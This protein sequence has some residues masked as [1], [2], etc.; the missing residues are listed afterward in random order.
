MADERIPMR[1]NLPPLLKELKFLS[2][3]L[4]AKNIASYA[5]STAFF[6]FVSLIPLLML[7]SALLPLTGVSADTLSGLVTTFTP[8]MADTLVT[9]IIREAYQ[10]SSGL[11]S[12]S[13]IVI[14]YTSCMGMLALIRGMNRIFDIDE[15]RN[16]FLLVAVAFFYT[17]LLIAV[18]LLSLVLNVFGETIMKFVSSH[19]PDFIVISPLFYN[20]RYLVV[21]AVAVLLFMLIY[22]FVPGKRQKFRNQWPG[23][24]FSALGWSIF[25]FVYSQFM[26]SDNIYNTYYGSLATIVILL[27]WLYGCFYI[28]LMGAYIN[29][30]LWSLRKIGRKTRMM[31]RR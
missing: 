19:L 14:V 16:Y 12:F 6:F 31:L 30:R 22:T 28:L 20:V 15:K 24:L 1:E 21:M 13:L 25:S 2:N 4:T 10:G 8:D 17:F 7:L 27:L 5:S 9:Y 11:L 29:H 23:A 18:I 3:D 26:N